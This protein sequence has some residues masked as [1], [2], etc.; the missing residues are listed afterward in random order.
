[1]KKRTIA[2][3]GLCVALMFVMNSQVYATP[4][5]TNGLVAEYEFDGNAND[6]SG[7]GLNGTVY[8]VTPT[9][10]RY[11]HPDSAYRFDNVDDWI[12]LEGSTTSVF[13]FNSFTISVWFQTDDDKA[14]P[15]IESTDGSQWGLTGYGVELG[16]LEDIQVAYRARYPEKN[17]MHAS[18]TIDAYWH[19]IALVRDV[20]HAEGYLYYDGALAASGDDPDPTFSVTP[21]SY[22]RFGKYYYGGITN[23]FDG[24]LDD[25]YF[26]NRALSGQEIKQLEPFISAMPMLVMTT[27]KRPGW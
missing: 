12:S 22:I 18:P 9:K 26:Y 3:L 14:Q 27:S 13:T 19:H 8:G 1:M 10:D 16:S 5:I 21:Q 24:N 6:T 25:I 15:L 7:H 11:G 20:S 23:Y 17:E 2:C 4:A